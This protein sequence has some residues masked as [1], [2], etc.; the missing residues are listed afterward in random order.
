[1]GTGASRPFSWSSELSVVAATQTPQQAR[2]HLRRL[3]LACPL[4]LETA[5]RSFCLSFSHIQFHIQVEVIR[6]PSKDQEEWGQWGQLL[7]AH[8]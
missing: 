3:R 4:G 7:G 1:M 6:F 2:E 5:E 8:G